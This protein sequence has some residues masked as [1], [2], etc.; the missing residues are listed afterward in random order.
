M[1]FKELGSVGIK[2]C[3]EAMGIQTPVHDH[4]RDAIA[5]QFMLPLIVHLI[6]DSTSDQRGGL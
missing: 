2:W 4:S 6:I 5:F 1:D 3:T